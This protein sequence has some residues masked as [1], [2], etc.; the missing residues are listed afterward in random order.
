MDAAQKQVA[1][2]LS[3][4]GA[5]WRIKSREQQLYAA[6]QQFDR[7]RAEHQGH[8]ECHRKYALA[9]LRQLHATR[10]GITRAMR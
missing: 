1:P 2:A 8:D 6:R 5:A 4:S 3:E 9:A 7:Y 10:T